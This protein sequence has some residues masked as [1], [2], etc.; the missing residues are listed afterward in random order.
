V[1]KSTL[2]KELAKEL[3]FVYVDT[4]AM[5]RAVALFCL[6]KGVSLVSADEITA[7]LTAL[8]V[9]IRGQ[10]VFLED[11]DVTDLLRS[12]EVAEASSQVAAV[13]SVRVKLVEMQQEMGRRGNVVMDGRDIC[14]HVLPWAQVKIYL[15][16]S[17]HER[18]RRRA[19]ELP[20]NG[21]GLPANE[22]DAAYSAV[23]KDL[24]ERDYRDTHREDSP[25]VRCVDAVYLD[26]S[27]MAFE[28]VKQAALDMVQKAAAK[29][30]RYET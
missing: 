16:A 8:H 30:N 29:L 2:A 23:R 27:G 12:P 3:S 6:R 26:T 25:L 10:R 11:E 14:A 24:E 18:T 22:A 17:I 28:E 20:V 21:A 1:G 7:A 4:G 15:D 5:Y 9:S 19:A 13:H